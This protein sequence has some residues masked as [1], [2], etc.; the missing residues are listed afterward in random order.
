MYIY[1]Y[2]YIYIYGILYIS[3]QAS[4][5]GSILE[6]ST[7][8]LFTVMS[9]VVHNLSDCIDRLISGRFQVEIFDSRNS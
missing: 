8:Q 5:L 2:I 9:I 7:W 1:I 3:H 6:V 4:N